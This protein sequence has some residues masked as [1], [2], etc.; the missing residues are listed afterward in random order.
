VQTEE[1]AERLYRQRSALIG[2][3]AS[4]NCLLVE[5]AQVT[6][7]SDGEWRGKYFRLT[8]RRGRNDRE[9]SHGPQTGGSPLL[10]VAYGMGLRAAEK[11]RFA[12][13]TTCT[14]PWCLVEHRAIDWVSRSPSRGSSLG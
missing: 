14:S 10:D 12:R 8:M 9:G 5:A 4:G 6:V 2:M 7:R 1:D 11:V 3:E 13:A